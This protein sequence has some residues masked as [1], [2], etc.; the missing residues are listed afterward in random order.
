MSDLGKTRLAVFA[1]AAVAAVGA[2]A[3]AAE[4]TASGP[5]KINGE[6]QLFLDDYVVGRMAG[7]TRMIHHPVRIDHPV[8]DSKRFGTWQPYLSVVFDDRS[9]RIRLWY[10]KGQAFGITESE[11]GIHWGSSRG[12]QIVAKYGCAVIDDG[13]RERDAKRRFKA[14]YWL[15]PKG[16]PRGIFV[17]FSPDGLAWTPYPG[18]PVLEGYPVPPAKFKR[19]QVGDIVDTYYDPL[20]KAYGAAL[21]MPALPEDGYKAAPRAGQ[22]FRRLV[23]ISFS[24]DFVHWSKPKR[25]FVPDDKDEGMLEFYGMGGMHLRGSLRIGFVR[26]LRDDLPCDK[27]GPVN[28]I[29]YTVLATSRDGETWHRYRAPFFDR[30]PKP[31]TWDHAMTWVGAVLPVGDEVFLYYG[32]YARGHKVSRNT[33]RQLGLARIRKDGYVSLRAGT[34]DGA[35]MTKPLVFDGAALTLNIDM[36]EGGV[37]R[38]E[39]QDDQGRALPGLRLAE[40]DP[41]VGDHIARMVTWKGKS[42]LSSLVGKPIRLRFLMRSADL[43][44]FQFT[45]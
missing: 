37:V 42:D 10:D 45:P 23:G 16:R 28:G 4:P 38:V 36:A 2:C 33:E 11:D 17:A 25:I 35:L 15:E 1:A 9:K 39:V 29:G 18:N 6:P 40:C 20:R 31:G 22:L 32:G 7:L 5:V 30:N 14:A 34:Q 43:Y 19:H 8:L 13:S 24:K 27:G 12:L 21:K 3:A 41:I 26:V 44:A